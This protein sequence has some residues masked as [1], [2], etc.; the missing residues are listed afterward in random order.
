MVSARCWSGKGG[1]GGRCDG[2]G[3]GERA[4]GRGIPGGVGDGQGLDFD[5]T[6]HFALNMQ[7]LPFIFS[8]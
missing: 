1:C 3:D 8:S 6:G 4:F 5:F 2:A 7:Q